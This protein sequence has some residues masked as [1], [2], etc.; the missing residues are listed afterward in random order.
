MT[1][2][3][4]RFLYAIPMAI[5][6]IFHLIGADNMKGMVPDFIPGDVFWVYLTGLAL[7]AASI[8][9]II[10][11]YDKIATLLLAIMLLIFVLT[12]HLPSA[13]SDN[14]LIAQMGMG[15]A[16]RDSAIAAGAF[17]LRPSDD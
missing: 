11:K 7:L 15:N 8:S 5:F 2:K 17:L 16:L 14:E 1:A 4:G 13:M 3:I 12:V 6:G 9:I 10:K